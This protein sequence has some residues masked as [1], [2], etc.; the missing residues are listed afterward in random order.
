MASASVAVDRSAP[1]TGPRRTS[2]AGGFSLVELLLVLAAIGL[3]ASVALPS[4][5]QY[6]LKSRR[7]EAVTA[8]ASVQLAQDRYRSRN[9]GYAASFAALGLP[10]SGPAS[11]H[12]RFTLSQAAGELD[13]YT[14]TATAYGGQARDED[15]Q[16]M[17]LSQDAGGLEHSPAACWSR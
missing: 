13:S 9:N 17:S 11:G 16:S 5:S 6:T 1:V 12:Y 7:I 4:Y 15:C 2:R 10:D 14:L 3:L 8:M